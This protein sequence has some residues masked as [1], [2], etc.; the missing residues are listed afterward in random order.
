MCFESVGDLICF[1]EDQKL[2]SNNENVKNIEN[3]SGIIAVVAIK[4]NFRHCVGCLICLEIFG[5]DQV[6]EDAAER[7]PAGVAENL[8]DN[9]KKMPQKLKEKKLMDLMYNS[10]YM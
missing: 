10:P 1:P 4:T 6:C 7:H 8:H 3:R 9:A 2:E 5:R